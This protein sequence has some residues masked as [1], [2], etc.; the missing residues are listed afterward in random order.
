MPCGCGKKTNSATVHFMGKESGETPQ[1]EEWGPIL[2]KYLHCL[3]EK[4]GSSGN[5]I[6]DADQANYTESI[7]SSLPLIIPCPECQSHAATY[8]ISNPFP[9]LKNLTGDN[10]RIT[11]RNWLF[12]FHNAVRERKNQP[13]IFNTVEESATAYANCFLPKCEYNLFI[14]N[15]AYAV[16]QNWVRVDNW[17]KWYSN[18][19][20][21]RI[22]AGNIVV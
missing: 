14:Q 10:L 2:W 5:P 3:A 16:R 7:I 15:V 21:L 9:S 12:T 13:I 17:R 1:P 11:V 8:M 19:E 22:L 6:V 18:S 20:K 4:L